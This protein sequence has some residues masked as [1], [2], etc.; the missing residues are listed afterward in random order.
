VE[1]SF[2]DGK[3]KGGLRIVPENEKNVD[4]PKAAEVIA[5]AY[6]PNVDIENEIYTIK[7]AVVGIREV[8]DEVKTVVD[9]MQTVVEGDKENLRLARIAIDGNG[10]NLKIAYL[11]IGV[12]AF[13][14]LANILLYL[15]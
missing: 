13:F 15:R 12:T 5:R 11:A 7:S 2:R 4:V 10:K 8:L 6:A 14:S 1:P 9:Q 3:R